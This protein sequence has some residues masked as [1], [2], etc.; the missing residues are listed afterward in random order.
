MGLV[1]APA[2]AAVVV[3]VPGLGGVVRATGAGGEP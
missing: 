1:P 3:T 2:G